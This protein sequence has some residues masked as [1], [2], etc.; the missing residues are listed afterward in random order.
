MMKHYQKPLCEIL[1]PLPE[2]ALAALGGTS[3][4]GFGDNDVEL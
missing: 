3:S 4:P 2:E 1:E